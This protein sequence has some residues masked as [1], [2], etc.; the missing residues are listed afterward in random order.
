ML[1]NRPFLFAAGLCLICS[2]CLTFAATALKPYQIKNQK[3]DK[4][5]NI[6]KVL[7]VTDSNKTYT[8]TDIE[9]LYNQYIIAKYVTPS[10]QLQDEETPHPIFIFVQNNVVSAYAIPISGYG[11]W[12]TLYG[13]FS[14]EGNGS[15]VKGITFYQHGETPGLGAEVEA[16]WFQ[17][18]FVGKKIATPSG[19]FT[20]VG[21]VRGKVVDTVPLP[22]QPYYVDGISGATVTSKGVDNFL[23]AGLKNYE[24]FSK[25][26]RRKERVI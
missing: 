26:L 24:A 25:R 4:Q 16:K 22:D 11:L 20:S 3:I 12:S 5:K 10:G 18:N 17:D 2:F 1:S 7:G 14:V 23:R 9:S 15:T 21:I 6:L 19:E 13:Y 8:N